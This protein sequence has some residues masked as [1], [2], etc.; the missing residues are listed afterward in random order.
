ME[1]NSPLVSV[2]IPSYNHEKYVQDTIKSIIRQTYRNIELIVV[3]DGSKDS[4]WLKIKEMQPDCERRFVRVHLET[5]ENEGTCKT[6][7]RLISLANGKFIY[8]IASDD[9]AKP[10]AIEKQVR[11]LC[12][13]PDYVLVVGDADIINSQ[14]KKIGW[15][16]KQRGCSLEIAKY[17]TFGKFLKAQNKDVNFYSDEFGKYKTFVTRNYVPNGKLIKADAIKSIGKFTKE[18]P[19]EDWYLMLQLSKIGKMKYLDEILFAYRWHDNNTVKRE[20]YMREIT[21]K[22]QCYEQKLVTSLEDKKWQQIFEKN[23]TKTNIKFKISGF[24]KY[25]SVKNLD[26]KQYILELGKY[27]IIIKTTPIKK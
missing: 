2:I 10:E 12:K 18:A 1:N 21:H 17:K 15:D 22:T 3:D 16:E 25:Y 20:N 24:L 13:N 6:L 27:K 8:L 14:S 9:M 5:K 26:I 4:S 19:L 7:N 11:F 23:I